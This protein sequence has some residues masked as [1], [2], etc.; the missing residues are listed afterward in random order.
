MK[1]YVINLNKDIEKMIEIL[2]IFV[3]LHITNYEIFDAING[4][5]LEDFEINSNW[6]DPWSHLHLTKGEVGCALSHYD[7]WRNISGSNY[8]DKALIFEDDAMIFN[9]IDPVKVWNESIYK[10]YPEDC[11]L[12]LLGKSM[13]DKNKEDKHCSNSCAPLHCTS[14]SDH[15]YGTAGAGHRKKGCADRESK[16]RCTEYMR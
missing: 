11:D 3:K 8:I 1:I 7:I 9:D 2:S 10:N 6:Y 4:N 15:M 16:R 14:K 12:L 13:H 5:K